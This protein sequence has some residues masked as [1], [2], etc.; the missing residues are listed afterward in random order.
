MLRPWMTRVE[1]HRTC[2]EQFS[3]SKLNL[4]ILSRV[5]P[6]PKTPYSSLHSEMTPKPLSKRSRTRG[7]PGHSAGVADVQLQYPLSSQLA[8]IIHD[9]SNFLLLHHGAD[10]HP[11]LSIESCYRRGSLPRRDPSS[12]CQASSLDVVLA[13]YIS[14]S[15]DHTPDAGSDEFNHLDVSRLLRLDQNCSR[16]DDSIDGLKPCCPHRLPGI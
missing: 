3:A 10:R 8:Q 1:S 15:R 12:L 14:L 6:S 13:Q 2:K 16:F 11:A 5:C 4:L 7:A 9:S